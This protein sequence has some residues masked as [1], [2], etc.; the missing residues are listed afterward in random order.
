MAE[1]KRPHL[2][3]GYWIKTADE[4]LTA[5]IDEAQSANGLARID[6]QVLN[7]LHE[8][9]EATTGQV[10]GT[11]RPFAG[12][13]ALELVIGRLASRDLVDQEAATAVFRL[14]EQGHLAH[15]AALVSQMEICRRAVQGVDE[16]D[17][18]TTV[19]VL[20]QLVKNLMG[21]NHG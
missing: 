9:G 4:A 10:A 17:Y 11:L 2:P 6:W 19:R 13:D 18:A 15:R 21:D 3:I 5:R 14:T 20:Q 8:M 1:Q 12:A 7:V 16:T